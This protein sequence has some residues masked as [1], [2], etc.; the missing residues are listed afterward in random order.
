MYFESKGRGPDNENFGIR[1]GRARLQ[2]GKESVSRREGRRAAR[3]RQMGRRAQEKR[4]A[5]QGQVFAPHVGQPHPGRN[6]AEGG[7]RLRC[8]LCRAALYTARADH[9]DAAREQGEEP[10]LCRQRR[11]RK[12]DRRFAAGKERDVR[13]CLLGGA[14]G[15]RLCRVH[16]PQ[17]DHHRPDRGR[18]LERAA[19][20]DDLRRH[21]VQGGL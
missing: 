18:T 7:G 4:P 21:E 14:P 9:G 15:A 12:R 10:R 2:S 8:D 19:D 20:P 13:L 5:Y 6:G 17:E 3:A 16:R 1:R 11:A